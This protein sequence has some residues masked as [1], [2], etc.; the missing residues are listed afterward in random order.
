MN[1]ALRDL[2]YAPRSLGRRPSLAIVVAATLA[3]GIGANTAM[4]SV[5]NAVL[6]RPLPYPNAERL[7]IVWGTDAELNDNEARVSYPD[8]RDW[9]EGI[10]LLVALGPSQIPRLHEIVVDFQVLVFTA[11]LSLAAGILV[12]LAPAYHTASDRKSVV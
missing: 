11:V 7:V 2:R 5:V 10:R 8:F 9:R 4:F 1:N 3:L 12:G 6:L